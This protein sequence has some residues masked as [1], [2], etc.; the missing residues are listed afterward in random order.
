MCDIFLFL[1]F[2]GLSYIFSFVYEFLINALAFFSKIHKSIILLEESHRHICIHFS[3]CH[4]KIKNLDGLPGGS[5]CTLQTNLIFSPAIIL[6]VIVIVRLPPVSL[7]IRSN[8]SIVGL[9]CLPIHHNSLFL[10][11]LLHSQALNVYSI[12]IL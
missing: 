11:I 5:P 8:F 2:S 1:V 7:T 9:Y 4:E 3:T 10:L 12:I 6:Q